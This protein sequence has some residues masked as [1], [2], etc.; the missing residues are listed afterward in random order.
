MIFSAGFYYKP[1]SPIRPPGT[2]SL[3]GFDG[4]HREQRSCSSIQLLAKTRWASND[5]I[6]PGSI[7]FIA[8]LFCEKPL[9]SGGHLMALYITA[10]TSLESKWCNTSFDI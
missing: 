2:V 5:H 10:S 9:G 4:G 1:W 8:K 6:Q 7:F 3:I